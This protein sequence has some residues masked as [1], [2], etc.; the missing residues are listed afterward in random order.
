MYLQKRQASP[1]EGKKPPP[2]NGSSPSVLTPSRA[3]AG[4]LLSLS[5]PFR[6]THAGTGSTERAGCNSVFNWF[7]R[8]ADFA[9]GVMKF[10]DRGDEVRAISEVRR[11]L[12][13]SR[14]SQTRS[15]G[16][17]NSIEGVIKG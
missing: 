3:H 9:P 4:A 5:P 2:L 7:S 12:S 11:L 16:L 6:D 15:T 14:Y 13:S 17:K 8:E 10:R 1:N